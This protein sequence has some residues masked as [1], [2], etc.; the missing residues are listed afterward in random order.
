MVPPFFLL[1]CAGT[2]S[3]F[4]AAGVELEELDELDELDEEA[5]EELGGVADLAGGHG[6]G[7]CHQYAVGRHQFLE[8]FFKVFVSC[9]KQKKI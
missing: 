6:T 8:Q 4:R 7:Q 5:F 9:A 2:G 1:G 3:I